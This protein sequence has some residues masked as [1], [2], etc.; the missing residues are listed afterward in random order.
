MATKRIITFSIS[1]NPRSNTKA[2]TQTALRKAAGHLQRGEYAAARQIALEVVQTQPQ[3]FD[4][5]HMLG[6]I[7]GHSQQ[8]TEAIA[9]ISKALALKPDAQAYCNRAAARLVLQ[10]H[11]KAIADCDQAIALKP[12]LAVAHCVRGHALAALKRHQEAF[13]S[14][15]RAV[16]LN[17]EYAEAW[18]HRGHACLNLGLVQ[19][20][21][22][23][24]DRA[25]AINPDNQGGL[26]NQSMCYLL[27]GDFSRGWERYEA[28]WKALEVGFVAPPGSGKFM[29]TPENFGK[30]LWGGTPTRGTVLVWPEQGIGDQ[31]IFASMLADLQ[32]RVGKVVL[33]LDERLHPLFARSF[34]GCEI[35][36][37]EASRRPNNY[38][39]QIPAGGLGK[40][41]RRSINDCIQHRRAFLVPD[42]AH[43]ARLRE[44][45]DP[46]NLRLCGLS[47]SS[48]HPEFGNDKS[49]ALAT[50]R[51]L[52]ETPG[53]RFVDLQYGDT[54]AERAA[55]KQKTGIDIVHLDDID[56]SKDIDGL[57]AL[58]D[59]CDVIVTISNTT[60]HIAGALGKEVWLMLPLNAARFWYWQTEREDSLW[61]PHMHIVRQHSIGDWSDVIAQVGKALTAAPAA[62]MPAAKAPAKKAAARKTPALKKAPAAKKKAAPKKASAPKKKK[63]AA[64]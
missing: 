7:A 37:R 51:P 23:S 48:I 25:L 62:A 19:N 2:S 33:A 41:F 36:T 57:A 31:I 45:I 44:S 10:H 11:A 60:A 3:H 34:P 8:P 55:L 14:Y 53:F 6:V 17:P 29:L 43:S 54:S 4:A 27:A 46:G 5:L 21:V 9:L 56:L 22:A 13:A 49:M 63:V 40:H 52:L 39:F 20:A 42:K 26:A 32:P 24:Y 16:E 35:I 58:I 15:D 50:L 30:P 64:K 1:H 47:W 38:D 61:Y 12:G 59:A 18:H 28:R